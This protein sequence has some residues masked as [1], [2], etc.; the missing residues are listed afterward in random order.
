MCYDLGGLSFLPICLRE[1]D[2]F[3]SL[4]VNLLVFAV[5]AVVAAFTFFLLAI[6]V[7]VVVRCRQR[8]G[9]PYIRLLD[10]TGDE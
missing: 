5:A 3:L 6:T 2:P 7:V 10:G 4:W 8:S 1:D 9:A